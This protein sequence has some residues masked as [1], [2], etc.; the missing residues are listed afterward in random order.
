MF[1]M[2]SS[3]AVPRRVAHFMH[4]Y[5]ELRTEPVLDVGCGVNTVHLRYFAPGSIGIDGA[6]VQPPEG[7]SFLRWNF[8]ADIRTQLEENALQSTFQFVWCQDVFEHVLAPHEFLLNLRR[9]I[10]LDGYLFLDVPLV[11]KLGTY[12]ES[13][14]NPLNYF[15]GFL[16]QDHV[17]FFTFNTL[18]YTAEYAGFECVDWYSPF[19]KGWKRPPALRV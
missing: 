10:K 9:S 8:S 15:R 4:V 13:R 5:P 14:N 6:E 17:N 3:G 2:K 12:A 19:F 7:R 1:F 16:S 11:N 18:R